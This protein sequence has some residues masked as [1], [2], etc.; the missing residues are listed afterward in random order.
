[1]KYNK[2]LQKNCYVLTL[3]EILRIIR[4]LKPGTWASSPATNN[5]RPLFP[6]GVH[7]TLR[8]SYPLLC[9]C[10]LRGIA[11]E[12]AHVPRVDARNNKNE[13]NLTR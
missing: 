4:A 9:L 13:Y 12:D 1:M 2:K 6:M 8:S 3:F 11:G 10:R 7:L 5:V